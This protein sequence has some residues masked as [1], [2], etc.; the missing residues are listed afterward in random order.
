MTPVVDYQLLNSSLAI[1]VS[2]FVLGGV[3]VMVRRNL[4]VICFSAA[5]MLQGVCLA[6]CSFGSF[7]ADWGGRT[8]GW[9][10]MAVASVIGFTLAAVGAALVSRF[11]TLRTSSTMDEIDRLNPA[12]NHAAPLVPSE[13]ETGNSS[14]E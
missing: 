5:I 11:R 4:A 3:G 10:A 14:A 13:C 9:M 2:L 12:R 1:A 6:F 7:H 8:T